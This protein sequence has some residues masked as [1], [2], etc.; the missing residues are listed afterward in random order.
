MEGLTIAILA[1][2]LL[3]GAGFSWVVRRGD[4]ALASIAGDFP[5]APE[6]VVKI[7]REAGLTW[8]ERAA[9]R[10]VP[11]VRDGDALKV[12][13]ECRAGVMSFEVR[14]TPSGSRVTARAQAVAVVRLPELGGLG[15]SAAGAL[16]LPAGLPRNPARLLRRRGRVFRAL[17]RAATGRAVPATADRWA[18]DAERAAPVTVGSQGFGS[19]SVNLGALVEGRRRR[20]GEGPGR[21]AGPSIPGLGRRRGRRGALA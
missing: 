9:G 20:R 10:H 19:R 5:L 13:I 14:R 16:Y 3:S 12:E 6:D 1:I 15:A 2:V 18:A 7:A 17:T 8:R 21:A 11:V 4:D